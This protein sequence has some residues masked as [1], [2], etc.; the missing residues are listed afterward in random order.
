M[1]LIIEGT[2][3][4][5]QIYSGELLLFDG[6]GAVHRIDWRSIVDS[7]ADKNSAVQTALRVAFSDSD[8]FYNQKVRKILCDPQ[9]EAPIKSQLSQLA[10]LCLSANRQD[11]S[12]NWRI[13]DTPFDF[14][15]TDTDI[16]YNHIFAAGNEGLFSAPRSGV[17]AVRPFGKRTSKHHDA[18]ILQVK[19]SDHY[20][21]IAAAAGDDGLFEFA[22]KRSESNVLDSERR[23]ASRPC[24][25]CDWA[26]QSVMG[27]TLA[28]AFLASFRQE[29][30][31]SSNKTSRIFDRIV[32]TREIFQG[33]LF[34]EGAAGMVWGCREKMYRFATDGI[35]VA[36]Y[37]HVQSRK[38]KDK[39]AAGN[40]GTQFSQQGK[41]K[42]SVSASSV[43]SV[44]TA[45]FGTVLELDDKLVVIRSD[46]QIEILNGEPVHWR[47]FPRSEHYSNQLH[48]IYDDRLE[49]ISFVH[50]YFVDQS[51]KLAGFKRGSNDFVVED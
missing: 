13:E 4:D 32:D 11:W 14:L 20:T 33:S 7:I 29:K 15:P 6:D 36:N 27:W 16:Y 45:P 40:A 43:V 8:L 28:N 12:N 46:G 9:I 38:S 42:T 10:T 22:F 44:G 37:S 3:W 21:A 41:V 49:I 34:D 31:P 1:K 24:S 48:I 2:Y 51:S 23:L 35:E 39:I 5:S 18:K 19:A 25:S 26:F 17:G 50:D 47:V 30:D